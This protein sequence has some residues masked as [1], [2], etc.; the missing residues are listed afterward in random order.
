MTNRIQ[1]VVR[2][3]I[4]LGLGYASAYTI[5]NTN[6]WLAGI[7]MA[8]FAIIGIANLV[9]YLEKSKRDLYNFLNAIRQHDFTQTS[10]Q[11]YS[12]EN[13]KL[14]QVYK[15][16]QSI[17][18]TLHMEKESHHL[19]LQTIIEHVETA[20]IAYDEKGQ[21]IEGNAAVKKMF[22]I[23]YF[24]NIHRLLRNEPAL[25]HR[26][27]VDHE[28]QFTH[29]MVTK[30]VPKI[31]SIKS[32]GFVIKN[33]SYRLVSFQDIRAELEEKELDSWQKLIRILTHEI[34]NSAIPISTLA[35]VI[36]Q[37]M[38]DDTE[39][40]KEFLSEEEKTDIYGGLKTIENRS[41]GLSA[42]VDSYRT[43]TKVKPPN[44]T[45]TNL[46]E[47]I[48]QNI[49]LLQSRIDDSGI[50]LS[51]QID[52]AEVEIDGELIS[53]VIINILINAIDALENT[54]DAKINV[55]GYQIGT[56]T[57]LEIA[58]NGCGMDEETIDNVFIPFFSTKKEGSG[59]GLSL[60]RQ[61]MR[62]HKGKI[63]VESTLN[64]GTKFSLEF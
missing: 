50:D 59:V 53:Q 60:A 5:L 29:R 55:R 18:R 24:K 3:L 22:G 10:L 36:S 14:R 31:L 25:Y 63:A 42:F 35:S 21:I 13:K 47:L 19:F 62:M 45:K 20:I 40:I 26:L 17:F 39:E 57:I 7:W 32:T 54:R 4:I 15:E 38:V 1:I 51:K 61:I 33:D 6:F 52:S 30:G 28:K 46:A 41:K 2:I 43:L 64:E 8:F 11:S 27:F 34:M 9:I 44:L 12:P 58:D 37:M 49:L 23:P 48:S 56:S 16:I